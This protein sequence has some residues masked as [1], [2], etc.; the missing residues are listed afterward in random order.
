MAND[1]DIA[2]E[3]SFYLPGQ[4]QTYIPDTGRIQNQFSFWPSYSHGPG[5]RVL[6]ITDDP[7]DTLPGLLNQ[8]FS[9]IEPV[10]RFDRSYRGRHIASYRVWL[11]TN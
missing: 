9:H 4:P 10:G 3:L 2:S 8:E 5:T 6:Y 1:N 7:I 11:L